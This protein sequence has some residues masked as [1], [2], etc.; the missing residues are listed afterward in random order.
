[1]PKT[2]EPLFVEVVATH[3]HCPL[4]FLKDNYKDRIGVTTV[5]G[6]IHR[7]PPNHVISL[8][9]K[10]GDLKD[11]CNT[12]KQMPERLQLMDVLMHPEKPKE[13]QIYCYVTDDLL[14]ILSQV[15]G[16]T[17]WIPEYQLYENYRPFNRSA[18]YFHS[19]IPSR[20]S[21]LSQVRKLKS[22][23]KSKNEEMEIQYRF[24]DGIE[25]GRIPDLTIQEQ[26]IVERALETNYLEKY[27]K[28]ELEGL[29]EELAQN[30]DSLAEITQDL[31]ARIYV[32]GAMVYF[33]R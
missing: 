24:H 20:E 32:M 31:F 2:K 11:I 26:Y 10:T 33:S 16:G 5:Q 18:E 21:F 25:K 19:F 4:L 9:V 22:A 27:N 14:N 6:I 28:K 15:E 30:L 17:F 13:S 29:A 8:R 23:L 12:I 1:M 7:S 3:E